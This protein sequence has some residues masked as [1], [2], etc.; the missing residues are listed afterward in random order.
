MNDEVLHSKTNNFLA[1]VYLANKTIGVSFLDVSTGEFLVAQGN[2]EYVDKLL[3]NFN[4]SE[5][6][7]PKNNKSEFRD[8]FGE[9]FHNFYLE[10]WIFKEDYA[11]ETLTK[12]FQTISLK[13]LM[14]KALPHLSRV[15]RARS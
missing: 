10:D 9:D 14:Q 4:P 6:L 11:L 12:H 8:I 3:Q 13:S 5:V 7:V 15:R 1:A 2:S